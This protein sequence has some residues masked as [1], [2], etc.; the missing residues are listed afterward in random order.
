[1]TQVKCLNSND[2]MLLGLCKERAPMYMCRHLYVKHCATS[3]AN[4]NVC[5]KNHDL[6]SFLFHWSST[7]N[8]MSFFSPLLVV[9][10]QLA[11]SSPTGNKMLF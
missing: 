10:L 6:H 1:M 5:V 2:L 9:A 8:S 3:E 7:L 4:I 11:N